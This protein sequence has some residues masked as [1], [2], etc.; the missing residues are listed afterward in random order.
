MS[1]SVISCVFPATIHSCFIHPIH[2]TFL[3][4]HDLEHLYFPFLSFIQNFSKALR[5]LSLSWHK[6]CKYLLIFNLSS[7]PSLHACP[8]SFNSMYFEK[9]FL[10]SIKCH[11]KH[12]V[13]I[14]LW[15]KNI[16]R[17][18]HSQWSK[19]SYLYHYVQWF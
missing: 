16:I 3:H 10:I 2:P 14:I 8:F 6:S 15:F 18:F 19:T 12:E 5:I 17:L 9:Y 13:L 7:I 1:F 11:L 4:F